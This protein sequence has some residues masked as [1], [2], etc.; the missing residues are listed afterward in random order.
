MIYYKQLLSQILFQLQHSRKLNAGSVRV[1]DSLL[2]N[3]NTLCSTQLYPSLRP[4]L[5]G[6]LAQKYRGNNDHFYQKCKS[7][8]SKV[9][10]SQ[11]YATRCMPAVEFKLETNSA[12]TPISSVVCCFLAT[13]LPP[14]QHSKLPRKCTLETPP[15]GYET[16]LSSSPVPQN[17][18]V[19]QTLRTPP[20]ISI[21]DAS[22]SV[23]GAIV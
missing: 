3:N 22:I 19:K 7:F 5:P 13:R 10:N 1:G 4:T 20:Q 21:S 9:I 14:G 8:I 15:S 12:H 18:I 11:F 2:C 17:S 6:N 16:F 23:I